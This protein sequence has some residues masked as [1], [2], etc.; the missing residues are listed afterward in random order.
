MHIPDS[1]SSKRVTS[2]FAQ[3]RG[4]IYSV[5]QSS[6]Y[7]VEDGVAFQ[8]SLSSTARFTCESFLIVDTNS[9]QIDSFLCL[10]AWKGKFVKYRLSTLHNDGSTAIAKRFVGAWADQLWPAPGR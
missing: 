7:K 3:A 5:R 6:N 1:L 8:I 10:T 9:R 2:Q 4:D